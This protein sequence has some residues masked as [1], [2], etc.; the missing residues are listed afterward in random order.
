M[1]TD[2][3]YIQVFDRNKDGYVVASEIK[4]VMKQLGQDLSDDDVDAII[5]QA[6]LDNDGRLNYKGQFT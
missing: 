2:S 4:Y 1:Y 6:D 3:A 5:R